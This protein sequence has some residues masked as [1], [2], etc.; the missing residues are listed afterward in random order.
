M[1]KDRELLED[2]GKIAIHFS[3][4]SAADGPKLVC[5]LM[6]AFEINF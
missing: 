6:P 2:E 5:A 3:I 4:N 1:L